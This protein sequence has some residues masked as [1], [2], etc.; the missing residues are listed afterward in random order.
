LAESVQ[1]AALRQP[2]A[3]R[4]NLINYTYLALHAREVSMSTSYGPPT[5]VY[6]TFSNTDSNVI[7][8]NVTTP[9]DTIYE[10]ADDNYFNVT[11]Q[12]SE[13][14]QFIQIALDPSVTVDPGFTLTVTNGSLLY[15]GV[16]QGSSFTGTVSSKAW[17]NLTFVPSYNVTTAQPSSTVILTVDYG[18]TSYQYNSVLYLYCFVEGTRIS[19]VDGQRDIE[20]LRAGDL[21]L[22]A[23]GKAAPIRFLGRRTVDLAQNPQHAP[24]RIPACAIADGIPSRDL[25]ISPD[26]AIVM[27]NV[28]IPARSLIGSGI[29]QEMGESITYYHIQ[30]DSHDIV[31]AENT[32]CETLLDTDDASSFDNGDEAV[33]TDSFLAPCLPRVTQGAEVEAARNHIRSRLLVLS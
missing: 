20:T 17:Q 28:L 13:V 3:V 21:V 6:V 19:C 12:T 8:P 11:S 5:P 27:E 30:L 15:G 31:L 16:N 4:Y 23:S 32:P 29:V 26:H 7:D 22:T 24:V 25:R 33:I 9:P 18:G 10:T 1:V 14:F 2:G